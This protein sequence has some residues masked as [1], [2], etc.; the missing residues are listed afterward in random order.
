MN[1]IAFKMRLLPGTADAYELAHDEIWPEMVEVIKS[2][3][4]RNYSI[5]RHDLDLFAYLEADGDLA[6]M[7]AQ[8]PVVAR[9]WR[10]MEPLMEYQPDG[11]PT[12]W[13]LTEVFHI[14]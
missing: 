6:E 11:T 13:P 3:G 14:D 12:M 9:W 7:G 4:V 5:F 8:N 1:R 10:A 2:A